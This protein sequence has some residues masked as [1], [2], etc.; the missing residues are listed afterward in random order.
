MERFWSKV[1]GGVIATLASAVIL[2]AVGEIG[3]IWRRATVPV[4]TIIL[5]DG[6]C[7]LGWHRYEAAVGRYPEGTVGPLAEPALI[8]TSKM[9]GRGVVME[10]TLDGRTAAPKRGG[11][12]GDHEG[13]GGEGGLP[14]VALTFCQRD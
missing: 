5:V 3:V 6:P 8:K 11:P 7:P 14:S 13:L 2:A 9:L 1:A 4:D 12:A 10:E